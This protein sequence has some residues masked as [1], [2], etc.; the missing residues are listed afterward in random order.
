M[1]VIASLL[2][3]IGS[4][5]VSLSHDLFCLSVIDHLGFA[6]L[7]Y[8]FIFSNSITAEVVV[9]SSVQLVHPRQQHYLK[10]ATGNV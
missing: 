3:Y 8:C 9:I 1:L 5:A 7:T 4:F 2:F 10:L 6:P